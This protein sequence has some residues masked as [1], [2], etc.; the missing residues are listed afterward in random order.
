[1]AQLRMEQVLMQSCL[2]AVSSGKRGRLAR[3]RSL[4][5]V[6]LECQHAKSFE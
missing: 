1:M 5:H 3:G 4:V 6:Y 2:N